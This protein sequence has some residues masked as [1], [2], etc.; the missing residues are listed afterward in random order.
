MTYPTFGFHILPSNTITLLVLYCKCGVLVTWAFHPLPQG[1][2][3]GLV[4][5][6]LRAH[7]V[8]L[9]ILHALYSF[10]GHFLRGSSGN[11]K[12]ARYK[13]VIVLT[14]KGR[15]NDVSAILLFIF[16][17]PR[18]TLCILP[19]I[20]RDRSDVSHAFAHNMQYISG[21]VRLLK[22]PV[23]QIVIKLLNIF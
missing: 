15:Y 21:D 9:A 12:T 6:T 10:P 7:T 2:Q 5:Y 11:H 1:I 4:S 19:T 16:D 22:W 14:W 18:T 13:F 17:E 23:T 8:T 3:Y 20:R